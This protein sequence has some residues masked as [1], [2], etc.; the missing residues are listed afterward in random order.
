MNAVRRISAIAAALAVA[1]PAVAAAQAK[2]CEINE[3]SP[4]QL[5]SAKIYLT[6]ATGS[7][8]E[9]EKP[10]HLRNAIQVL[11]E[12]ADK[13][14]NP[15]G[16]NWLLAR[17]L[18][19]W[20][21]RPGMGQIVP[22]GTLGF[23]ERPNEPIDILAAIDTALTVVET[24]APECASETLPYRRNLYAKLFN[25]SVELFN[26]NAN[27]SAV[28]LATRSLTIYRGS[29]T[30]YNVLAGV[31]LRRND[32]KGALANFERVVELS[33][34]DSIFAKLKLS[35]LNN[36][37][38]ISLQ[39]AE[40]TTGAARTALLTKSANYFKAYLALVPSDPGAQQGLSRALSLSGDTASVADI[41]A[42]M[43]ANP[44]R[45]SDIQ[46]F[47]A[48][49]NAAAA[50]RYDDAVKMLAAGLRANPYYRDAL[51]NLSNVYFDQQKPDEMLPLARRLVEVDP[52]NPDNWRLLAGV[53]QL[54]SKATKDAALKRTLTDSLVKFLERS[55]KATSRVSFTTF[56]H[57][58]ARHTLA[59]T[60]E[61]LGAAAATYQMKLEFL[62][63]TG[64]VV[65]SQAV[66]V[67]PV[68][69]KGT[70]PFTATVQQAGIV[71]FRY[72]PLS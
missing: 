18:Y 12:K 29:P 22:R 8:K 63:K 17:A 27:D 34:S 24:S 26:T 33:G 1:L 69:P 49:S 56:Q 39:A 48:G 19:A 47:E 11:T 59:G 67:G 61:N 46:L 58:G 68:P 5:A 52:N 37:G 43:I 2:K 4:F 64:A 6:K 45:Y 10:K 60:I 70:L 28:A 16:R 71:A 66:S 57:A 14:G 21:E 13:I 25:P 32:A 62:D 36:L 38:V 55:T 54:R 41:Y 30:A 23:T 31:A 42:S 72:A 3:K 20:N 40:D 53:Y 50:K 9:D 15:V 51:F 7:G 65:A 44:D 35:A